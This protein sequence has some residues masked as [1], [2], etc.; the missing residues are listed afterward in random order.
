[1]TSGKLSK[2][3]L[4]KVFLSGIGFIVLLY[5][6]FSFF[7]GP[8]NK[9]RTTMERTIADLQKKL[10][11]ADSETKKAA[12]LEKQAG[13]ATERYA[14][15]KALT[16]EGAPI[17]WFPPRMKLFFANRQIEKATARLDSSSAY[18]EA[19][20]ADWTKNTWVI[21]LPQTDF[22]TAARA[23]ADLENSEPLMTIAKISIKAE[24]TDPQFQ[25]V[26]LSANTAMMKR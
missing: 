23:I 22:I 12:N 21:D 19:E 13:V 3:Q 1:M 26:N 7:L 14:A 8:L 20:L 16:P 15:I 17:A 4:Q 6:Y 2:D 9:S 25:Q 18:K 5:V 11:S 10:S 24:S